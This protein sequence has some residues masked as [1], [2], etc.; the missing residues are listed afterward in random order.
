MLK[1]QRTLLHRELIIKFRK[2]GDT[3]MKKQIIFSILVMLIMSAININAQ[4]SEQR[5]WLNQICNYL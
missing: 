1:F 4:T 5:A 3:K 2:I